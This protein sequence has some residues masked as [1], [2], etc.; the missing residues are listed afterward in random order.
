[1]TTPGA[2]IC[3]EARQEFGGDLD[4]AEQIGQGQYLEAS[5]VYSLVARF[6]TEQ[7]DDQ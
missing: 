6:L 7:A 1:L 4:I 2:T 3:D 5:E